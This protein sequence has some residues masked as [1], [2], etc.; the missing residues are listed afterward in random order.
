MAIKIEMLRCFRAVVE[1]GSLASASEALGRTP[2]AVSMMLRQF[3]DHVGAPLFETTRKSRLTPLGDMIH[4]EAYRELE[5]FE[6][7]VAVIEGLSRAEMGYVRLAVTPSIATTILPQIISRFMKDHPKVHIDM[8]DMNSD[9]IRTE[10]EKERVDIGLATIAACPNLDRR[11]L[12][13]DRFGVVCPKDHPLTQNREKLTWSDMAGYEFISHGLCKLIN[14]SD[15]APILATSRLSGP[16]TASLLGLVGAGVGITVLPR[17]AVT[18]AHSDIVFLPLSDSEASRDLFLITQP[19][20]MLNP[21][22]RAFVTAIGS[23]KFPED[24]GLGNAR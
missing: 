18:T 15:F 24:I 16:N 9:A 7:T 21:A 2:S 6:Q 12:F 5:H 14:D 22:A 19:R 3:E 10:L 1:H 8:H 13:S 17:L 11:K 23:A 20:Q 4:T